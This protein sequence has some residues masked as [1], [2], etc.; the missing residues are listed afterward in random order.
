MY[1]NPYCWKI[2][3]ILMSFFNPHTDNSYN[4]PAIMTNYC[5]SSSLW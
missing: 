1:F 4:N 3:H 2:T 5:I